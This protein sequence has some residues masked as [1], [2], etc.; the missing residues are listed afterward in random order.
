MGVV[1][2]NGMEHCT[3][4]VGIILASVV[5]GFGIGVGIDAITAYR[6]RRSIPPELRCTYPGCKVIGET[7]FVDHPNKA[8]WWVCRA[9][10]AELAARGGMNV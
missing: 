10:R 4:L 1:R 8:A 5:G 7:T 2:M 9:H 6:K 3:G